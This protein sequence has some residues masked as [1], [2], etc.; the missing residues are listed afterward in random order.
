MKKRIKKSQLF[1][2]FKTFI[3]KG[4]AIELAVGVIIASAFTAIVNSVVGGMFNPIISL[5]FS[6]LGVST[7][8]I[9]WVMNWRN[10][11]VW[12]VTD[13]VNIGRCFNGTYNKDYAIYFDLGSLINAV[14]YFLIVAIILFSIV[15]ISRGIKSRAEKLE[16]E[17]LEK[18]YLKHPEEKPQPVV[19]EKKP[20]EVDL[21][22]E[23][24]D[25]LLV[26]NKKDNNE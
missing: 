8:G 4:N 11:N 12:N 13:A 21:L 16:K 5:V 24:R 7:D 1:K 20:T 19:E 9:G 15:K 17:R 3:S 23:I 26:L 14:L 25:Q 10:P 18:Y 6:S 22:S 2:E